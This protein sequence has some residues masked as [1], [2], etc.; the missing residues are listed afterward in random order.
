MHKNKSRLVKARHVLE[1]KDLTVKDLF[2]LKKALRESKYQQKT[3][4]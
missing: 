3:L 4:I 2:F 1:I